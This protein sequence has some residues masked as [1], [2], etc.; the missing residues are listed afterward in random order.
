MS[1]RSQA[2]CKKNEI[3][4]VNVKFHVTLKS[5]LIPDL[6]RF[7]SGRTDIYIWVRLHSVTWFE[8]WISGIFMS[9][10]VI[11]HFISAR[12]WTKTVVWVS[13][14]T[15]YASLNVDWIPK[16]NSQLQPQ[17][18]HFSLCRTDHYSSHWR[19]AKHKCHRGERRNHS[20]E[21]ERS[22]EARVVDEWDTRIDE[23]H[24]KKLWSDK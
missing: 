22:V 23:E 6:T 24:A 3:L 4:G 1:A 11:Y 21:D 20:W 2:E 8:W 5:N 9:W 7:Y 14:K 13:V 18:H 16:A 12:I 19:P 17:N 10:H 15:E